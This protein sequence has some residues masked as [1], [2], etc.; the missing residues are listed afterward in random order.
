MK[1]SNLKMR[2]REVMEE[3]NLRQTDV[4][5]MAE[6]YRSAHPEYQDVELRRNDIS[7]YLSKEIEPKPDKLR[8]L[9]N[10][11]GVTSDWLRGYDHPKTILEEALYVLGY[12]ITH[13]ED[14]T[15]IADDADPCYCA[16][17]SSAAWRAL[18]STNDVNSVMRD[19]R[20]AA[21]R[22][23]EDRK[24]SLSDRAARVG[25]LYDRA[26]ARDQKLV[27]TVLEPY[28]DGTIPAQA[29]P[30][31]K[32]P[33]STQ[34]IAFPKVKHRSDGFCEITVYE[35]QL[36]AAGPSSYFDA[37]RSHIEQYPQ[38]IIPPGATFAVPIAGNSME[39]KFKNGATVFVQFTPRIENGE[40]GLFSLN[41]EP[42]IK[43]LVVDEARHEVRLHS[44]NPV[45]QDI[46]IHEGDYLY[47]F[48]RVLGS[49]SV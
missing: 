29:I 5:A 18:L 25:V 22:S 40:I 44:L 48:G 8:L 45:Y 13:T 24:A 1:E 7:Q 21:A 32:A 39:P 11:L 3:R 23:T 12:T 31:K 46:E 30:I 26:D 6:K 41:G 10:T 9:A 14:S 17:Y 34:V 19:L 33:T 15:C 37:P 47:T 20:T 36:P 28:D 43:Q 2:L 35:D 16:E 38:G 27:D 4:V 49:Y 42:Y